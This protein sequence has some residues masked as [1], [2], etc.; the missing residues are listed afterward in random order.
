[1][2]AVVASQQEA[3]LERADPMVVA[4]VVEVVEPEEERSAV[5]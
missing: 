1:M 4:L 5:V 2:C 3:V